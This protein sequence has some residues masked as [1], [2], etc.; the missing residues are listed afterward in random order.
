MTVLT[1]N[2]RCN[3]ACFILFDTLWYVFSSILLCLSLGV[4]FFK[5]VLVTLCIMNF[6]SLHWRFCYCFSKIKLFLVAILMKRKSVMAAGQ[7]NTV[8]RLA[9]RCKCVFS[10]YCVLFTR[11]LRVLYWHLRKLS[12]VIRI[13]FRCCGVSNLCLISYLILFVLEWFVQYKR[14]NIVPFNVNYIVHLCFNLNLYSNT[15]R[16]IYYFRK[17]KN[18]VFTEYLYSVV[19]FAEAITSNVAAYCVYNITVSDLR[20]FCSCLKFFLAGSC[21]S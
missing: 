21:F 20:M 15:Y 2:R 6:N 1:S 4:S 17:K 3:F 19:R 13:L 8:C 10:I 12:R 11:D 5:T 16:G 7:V 9:L 18:S 14:E